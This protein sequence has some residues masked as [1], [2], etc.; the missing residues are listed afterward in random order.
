MRMCASPYPCNVSI[1]MY[2]SRVVRKYEHK[3]SL[4]FSLIIRLP[5]YIRDHSMT[6][7]NSVDKGSGHRH[8]PD[9]RL[10]RGRVTV[11][12]PQGVRCVLKDA[13]G[14]NGPASLRSCLR[15]VRSAPASRRRVHIADAL[16]SVSHE[17]TSAPLSRSNRTTSR[18]P[19]VAARSRGVL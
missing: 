5:E 4:T 6:F 9:L 1:P 3:S 15:R 18:F 11:A 2:R 10:R 19:L 14:S 16:C 17:S 12:R 8:S 13:S 7:P